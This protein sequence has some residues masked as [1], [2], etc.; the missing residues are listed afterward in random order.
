[1]NY[2][3][4]IAEEI[5]ILPGQALTGKQLIK[6]KGNHRGFYLV[7][8]SRKNG[9]SY[10]AMAIFAWESLQQGRERISSPDRS[11]L[12]FTKSG[13]YVET[14]VNIPG[15]P[16]GIYQISTITNG[17]NFKLRPI[18][19]TTLINKSIN[20]LITDGNMRLL[21]ASAEYI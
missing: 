1:L 3:S 2:Y 20:P 4:A 13:D 5:N 6:P 14:T 19:S 16:A 10:Q 12:W 7:R 9:S 17:K 21:P 8:D 15:V 18:N 11:V